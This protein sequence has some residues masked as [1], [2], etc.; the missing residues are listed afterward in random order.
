MGC[1]KGVPGLFRGVPGA[2]RGCFGMFWGCS[3]GVLGLTD[4]RVLEFLIRVGF[5]ILPEIRN[6]RENF[7]T[8]VAFTETKSY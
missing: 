4:T 5:V 8:F 3:R 2:F 6:S 1:F 7:T